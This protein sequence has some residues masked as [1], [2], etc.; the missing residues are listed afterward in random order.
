MFH[1]S[2]VEEKHRNFLR[3]FWYRDNNPS[4]SLIEYR[5]KVH[6]F[7]NRPFPAFANYGLHKT[8][9]ISVEKYGSGVKTL[10]RK[11]FYVDDGL[12][13][14]PS[15]SEAIDLMTRTMS[16]LKNEGNL[17]IHKV[18][19][20]KEEV[21][22][23]FASD[24]LAKD[25]KDL[26]IGNDQ[27]PVQRSLGLNWD[28]MSDTFTFRVTAAKKPYTPRG[29]LSVIDSLYDPLGL[30]APVTIRGKMIL[31]KIVTDSSDWDSPLPEQY[32]S[33]WESQNTELQYL[34]EVNIR[35]T[36]IEHDASLSK[37]VRREIHVYSD[38]SEDANA[39]V[40]YLKN[41]CLDCEIHV[42]IIRQGKSS[43]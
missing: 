18:A 32:R 29:I 5:M 20:N 41:I 6:V 27:L 33:E 14:L 43:A 31:R 8:A 10:L 30:V 26:D 23:A 34:E 2:L 35:R 16:A 24:D 1:S 25:L 15:S 21:M 38:T 12:I 40:A 7:G 19:S 36:Y 17:R 11:N 28:L 42:G 9:E 37:A 22:S 3:L 4:N 13:S 39:A